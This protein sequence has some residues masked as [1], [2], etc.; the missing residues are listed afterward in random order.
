MCTDDCSWLPNISWVTREENSYLILGMVRTFLRRCKYISETFDYNSMI[1]KNSI[2]SWYSW[3][4]G[5]YDIFQIGYVLLQQSSI[6]K[7][8]LLIKNWN[9]VSNQECGVRMTLGDV[10]AHLSKTHAYT[11]PKFQ[12]TR[13]SAL[14]DILAV[15]R[16]LNTY[17]TILTGDNSWLKQQNSFKSSSIR[18]VSWKLPKHCRACL[19]KKN[20]IYEWIKSS[21]R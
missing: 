1:I 5:I 14:S 8:P 9:S 4:I 20:N 17:V 7:H 13:L 16:I 12:R 18:C 11:Y 10:T 15:E 19:E 21:W 6:Q 2:P 3:N